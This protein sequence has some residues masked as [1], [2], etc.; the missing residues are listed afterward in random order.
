MYVQAPGFKY[1]KQKSTNS[2]IQVRI[3]ELS[4]DYWHTR[5]LE[6]IASTIVM[7]LKFDASTIG[8]DFGHFA[9]ILVDIDL[10]KL[11]LE[12]LLLDHDGLKFYVYFEY[13]NMFAF[14]TICSSLGHIAS[15]C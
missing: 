4:W 9:K 3:H 10:S 13:E 14:C 5:I 1:W 8:G 6:D 7:R 12:L 11:L 15:N 2:K